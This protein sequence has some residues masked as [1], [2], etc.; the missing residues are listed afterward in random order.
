MPIIPIPIIVPDDG[1]KDY[2]VPDPV[3][4]L[5]FGGLIAAV[6]GI[7]C[8]LIAVSMEIV[9]DKNLDLLFRVA[10]IFIVA[11]VSIA[12]IGIILALITGE[13]VEG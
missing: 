7:V 9:F 4:Y 6:I 5:M 12:L 8:I 3:G 11:G 13:T 10:M 2:I 1:S